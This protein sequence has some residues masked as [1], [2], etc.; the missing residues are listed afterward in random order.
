MTEL[1]NSRTALVDRDYHYRKI[2][3]DTPT[4]VKLILANRSAGVACWGQY[5]PGDKFWTHW[6][7]LPTFQD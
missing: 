2:D 5:I 7:P 3:K 1:N 4:G 6:A